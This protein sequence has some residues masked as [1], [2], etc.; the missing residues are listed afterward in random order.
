[1]TKMLNWY[2]SCYMDTGVRSLAGMCRRRGKYAWEENAGRRRVAD[3]PSIFGG[4]I[5]HDN[6]TTWRTFLGHSTRE[7]CRTCIP[8]WSLLIHSAPIPSNTSSI[9]HGA[10]LVWEVKCTAT[11]YPFKTIP[12]WLASPY[13]TSSHIHMSFPICF[14]IHLVLNVLIW[15]QSMNIVWSK[16][17][18][19]S[20]EQ[21][22]D[23]L[24]P[25]NVCCISPVTC[26]T[27]QSQLLCSI[28]Y[29]WWSFLQ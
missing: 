9:S 16:C 4:W 28:G 24:I 20:W 26:K 17:W 15:K 19:R 21:F 7:C 3:H 25:R 18:Q 10:S 6:S 1:M 8:F 23:M 13:I 11:D 12:E 22:M 29:F 5:E 14:Q 27:R 2:L